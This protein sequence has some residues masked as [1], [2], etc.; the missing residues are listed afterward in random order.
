VIQTPIW[1][2]NRLFKKSPQPGK[3]A[4]QGDA[5]IVYVTAIDIN[6]IP[7]D[8]DLHKVAPWTLVARV[9]LNMDETI[10]RE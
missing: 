4:V 6:K 7:E 5:S 2:S 8:V 1:I 10:T 9:L 3:V